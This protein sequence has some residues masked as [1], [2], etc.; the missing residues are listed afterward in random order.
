MSVRERER[1]G[2]NAFSWPTQGLRALCLPAHFSECAKSKIGV[3]AT[4][5]IQAGPEKVTFGGVATSRD[6]TAL[7][8]D[9]DQFDAF[10]K[11]HFA[12][13]VW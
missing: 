5:C 7:R 1:D 2:S 3:V 10:L 13:S 8:E 11:C 9:A 12:F 4:K 6:K